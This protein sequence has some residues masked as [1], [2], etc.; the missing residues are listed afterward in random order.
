MSMYF[1]MGS[2]RCA[3]VYGKDTDHILCYRITRFM[4]PCTILFDYLV[5][6]GPGMYVCEVILYAKFVPDSIKQ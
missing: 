6:T 4:I 5:T 2:P 1:Y 3:L